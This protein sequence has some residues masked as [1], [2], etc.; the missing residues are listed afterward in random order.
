LGKSQKELLVRH[1]AR[2]FAD[3]ALVLL[4]LILSRVNL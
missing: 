3:F 1:A 2:V 4:V